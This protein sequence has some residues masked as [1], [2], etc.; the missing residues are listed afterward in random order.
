MIGLLSTGESRK[1]LL[2]RA[3]LAEPSVLVLDEPFEGLAPTV[4]QE[5]FT[6]FDRLRQ[7]LEHIDQV[8]QKLPAAP[9]SGT[10]VFA[11]AVALFPLDEERA[12]SA[13]ACGIEDKQSSEP[14]VELFE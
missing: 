8:V 11:Q 6:V 5:L 2:M 4:V 14:S 3:L 9:L 7:R 10:E 13:H 12:I 1:V